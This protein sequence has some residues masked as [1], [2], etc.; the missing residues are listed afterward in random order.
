VLA[1]LDLEAAMQTLDVVV[2]LDH[3]VSA[4]ADRI[5]DVQRAAY[6]IEADLI[7]FDGIP[8]LHESAAQVAALDLSLLGIFDGQRLAALLGY[9]RSGPRVEID[10]LAVHPD[11]F[12]RGLARRLI[13]ALHERE[14]DAA[15]F[16]VSTGAANVPALTLYQQ[17]GYVAIG[18]ELLPEGVVVTRLVRALISP[19]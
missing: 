16:D 15:R 2:V 17:L 7:A 14:S 10:R 18:D 3:H 13:E 6:R 9:T 5:V 1:E 4:V 8:P 11:Y 12:R 19:D